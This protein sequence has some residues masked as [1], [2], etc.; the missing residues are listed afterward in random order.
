MKIATSS[1]NKK[2]VNEA[3][4]AIVSEISKIIHSP[5][6]ILVYYTETQN[7]PALKEEFKKY[8]PN[9]QLLACS[10]CQATLSDKG[11]LLG[12]SIAALA[13]QDE[14]GAYGTSACHLNTSRSVIDQVKDVLQQAI[15]NSKRLGEL[16]SLIIL[17]STSGY[18]EL[19]LQGI[20]DELG[21]NIPIIGG[22][23]ADDHIQGNWTL[24]DTSTLTTEGI[25]MAVLY[26]SA[27]VSYSFHS[28][29]VHTELSAIATKVEGRKLQMLN[30]LPAANVY[31][32]WY[33]TLSKTELDTSAIFAQS[34]LYPLGRQAG[35]IHGLPY[36][37]LTHPVA[38]TPEGGIEVFC[39]I[40]EGEQIYLMTGTSQML[41][42]RAAKV[43]D[44]V[45][46]YQ[47]TSS[48]IPIG[49]IAI[50]YAGCMLHVMD[51]LNELAHNISNSMH[52]APFICPFTF[53]EQGQFIG[54]EIRHGNL[55]ISAVLFHKENI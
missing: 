6:L 39:S 7:A 17:H 13:I 53:G 33:K 19:I 11:Y 35:E 5:D 46:D 15:A 20:R 10:S 16:P 2:L 26:P 23:A 8:Y 50:Y 32:N 30:G 47:Q 45:N 51:S 22:T 34:T 52:K 14:K 4:S 41:I 28:G 3:V 1:S 18:E 48:S 9:S 21:V 44:S 36:F 31:A 37:S 12:H 40:N 38:I 27:R 24:F 25:A 43:V 55:M 29:Y 49:G 54:G 42:S